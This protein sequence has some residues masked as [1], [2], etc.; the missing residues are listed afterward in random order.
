MVAEAR[1]DIPAF[2]EVIVGDGAAADAHARAERNV[3]AL[4]GAMQAIYAEAL[5]RYRATLRARHPI[6]L[7][8]FTGNGGALSLYPA[9]GEPIAALDSPRGSCREVGGN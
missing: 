9:G 6:I 5:L 1:S 3:L 7:A 2:M 8:L 4:D